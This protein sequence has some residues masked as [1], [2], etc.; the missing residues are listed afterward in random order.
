M[1]VTQFSS[2]MQEPVLEAQYAAVAV[3]CP[4]GEV[5]HV[6][7]TGHNETD[8]TCPCGKR[9]RVQVLLASIGE[10]ENGRAA[11]SAGW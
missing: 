2:G 6:T 7:M 3:H 5:T 10:T 1:F 4:C 11:D 8:V 9:W